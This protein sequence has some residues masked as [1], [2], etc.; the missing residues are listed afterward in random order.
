MFGAIGGNRPL[1]NHS[2]WKGSKPDYFS[3]RAR[4]SITNIAISS[5]RSSFG[6]VNA[7]QTQRFNETTIQLLVAAFIVT[8]VVIET[9]EQEEGS[10][11]SIRDDES[12][13][14]TAEEC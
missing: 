1:T 12:I 4:R 6:P 2:D 8:R 13:I 3:T 5:R 10:Y 9:R 11:L 7:R 14:E